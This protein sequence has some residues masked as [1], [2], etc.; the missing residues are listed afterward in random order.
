MEREQS[1][2]DMQSQLEEMSFHIGDLKQRKDDE[3]AQ[4]AMF[5]EDGNPIQ[6]FDE[7][8]N[9]IP[10]FDEDG[11]AWPSEAPLRARGSMVALRPNFNPTELRITQGWMWKK[12]KGTGAFGRKNWKRRFF[13]VDHDNPLVLLFKA[14]LLCVRA[15]VRGT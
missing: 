5:D 2:A 15:C 10:M 4:R 7:E 11:V 9:P 12:G 1:L 6:Q 13:I 8:G 14:P 3:E